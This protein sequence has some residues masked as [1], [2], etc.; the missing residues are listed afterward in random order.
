MVATR[1]IRVGATIA[2]TVITKTTRVGVTVARTPVVKTAEMG[3]IVMKLPGAV[4]L[5]SSTAIGNTTTEACRVRR[6]RRP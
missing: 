1:I 2:V 4:T 3:L 6:A 5:A